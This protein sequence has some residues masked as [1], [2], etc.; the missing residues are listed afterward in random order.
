MVVI[1]FSLMTMLSIRSH[2]MCT[3]CVLLRC[4]QT[5]DDSS[6]FGAKRTK[7]G[8]RAKKKSSK[9][10]KPDEARLQLSENSCVASEN[11][12]V[13][14]S[15]RKSKSKKKSKKARKSSV[16]GFDDEQETNVSMEDGRSAAVT[17]FAQDLTDEGSSVTG[18]EEERAEDG[19]AG[20]GSRRASMFERKRLIQ[21]KAEERR[22]EIE[23]KRLEK[24]DMELKKT[25]EEE[26][27]RQLLLKL[28]A[29]EEEQKRQLLLKL[30]GKEEQDNSDLEDK[31]ESAVEVDDNSVFMKNSQLELSEK[32]KL[33]TDKDVTTTSPDNS[34][35]ER[36]LS[37]SEARA[38]EAIRKAKEMRERLRKEEEQ[39]KRQIEEMEKREQERKQQ[40]EEQQLQREEASKEQVIRTVA[41]TAK[42][43]E[44]L[45]YMMRLELEKQKHSQSIAPSHTFSYFRYLPQKPPPKKDKR[46]NTRRGRK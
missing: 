33:S 2:V 18:S 1:V 21:L 30:V 17:N 25:E 28:V 24:R 38:Q 11:V 36:L 41:K 45:D 26:R 15:K 40:E 27:K 39:R 35:F 31:M 8:I 29:K 7:T 10:D 13:D 44:E 23:R 6:R 14:S 9:T 34:G 4:L 20:S 5:H 3:L 22:K 43:K 42:G 12:P 46:R 16:N 37:I 19:K 32:L